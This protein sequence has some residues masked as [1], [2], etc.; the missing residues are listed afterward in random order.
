M[1]LT[2]S[3]ITDFISEQTYDIRNTHNGRWID[4]KCAADV[5]TVIADCILNYVGNTAEINSFTT[6][7]IWF[8]DLAKATIKEV[9]KKPNTD[10]YLAKNE[11]DKFFQQPM[12][13]LAASN[14]LS[15]KKNGNKNVYFISNFDVLQY[16]ALREKNALFF[17]KEY[18]TKTLKDCGIYDLFDTFFKD[19]TPQNYA[20]MKRGFSQ[21][22]IENTAI[23]G[24]TE[25]N[26]IFIKVL[27][28]L[29]YYNNA[30]G[31][32][33]GYLS[34]HNITYDMLMY[35]RN[36]FRDINAEKPKEMT[37]KEYMKLRKIKVNDAF[38]KYQ[39]L[40]AKH[41]LRLFNDQYRES[42]SEHYDELCCGVATQVHHIFPECQYPE[43]SYY[44]EN[45]IALTPSQHM[46]KAHPNN[47]TREICEEYQ[48][49][50]LLSKTN[51]IKENL[52][53]EKVERIYEF[54]KLLYVL[55]IGFNDDNILNIDNFDFPAVVS[56][57]NLYYSA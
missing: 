35:N 55:N 7:D 29:S 41:Y 12:E 23:N 53:D 36:N 38:S 4:Q 49:L 21:F 39:S 19:Q 22:T 13:L 52:T 56:A 25:C 30:L 20:K 48:H 10:E 44:L 8:S 40:K 24:I 32:K 54:S 18:I 6:K 5:L 2:K 14:V 37:R 11:Y 9:F 45:L 15:K 43:I 47:N 46:T 26:R 42:K 1:L 57:I 33:R 50:L 16:I 34:K 17:L 28:P 51:R 27:N 3:N 31:T